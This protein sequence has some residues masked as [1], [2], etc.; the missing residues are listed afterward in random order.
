MQDDVRIYKQNKATAVYEGL[1][2]IM[3]YKTCIVGI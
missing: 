3:Y 2:L 1:E